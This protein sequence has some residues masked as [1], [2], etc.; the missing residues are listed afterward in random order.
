MTIKKI[1][2]YNQKKKYKYKKSLAIYI[3]RFMHFVC[4]LKNPRKKYFKIVSSEHISFLEKNMKQSISLW[5]S[6][7]PFP[8]N[9][10]CW[11]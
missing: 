8:T 3:V 6:Y 10:T 7:M 1:K 9:L 2:N 5:V 4:Y 11:T